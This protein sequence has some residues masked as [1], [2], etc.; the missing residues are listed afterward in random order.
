MQLS[1]Q[2]GYHMLGR[3]GDVG[4]LN[5]LQKILNFE[6]FRNQTLELY[7]KNRFRLHQ[8]TW[9]SKTKLFDLKNIIIFSTNIEGYL[10]YKFEFVATPLAFKTGPMGFF[11]NTKMHQ[12]CMVFVFH[13]ITRVVFKKL[14]RVKTKG[15]PFYESA[16]THRYTH[17]YIYIYMRHINA[18]QSPSSFSDNGSDLLRLVWTIRGRRDGVT[19]GRI[20]SSLL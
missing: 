9:R 18:H 1:I 20:R 19:T 12:I 7:P 11:P 2:H 10:F 14:K 17:I 13:Y 5:D 6:R 3:S 15:I 8:K 4:G 16:C